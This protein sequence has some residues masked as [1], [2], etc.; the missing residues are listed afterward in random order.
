VNWQ[1]FPYGEDQESVYCYSCGTDVTIDDG[2]CPACKKIFQGIR[3][4][5]PYCDEINDIDINTCKCSYTYHG[6]PNCH[7]EQKPDTRFCGYCGTEINPSEKVIMQF[8]DKCNN[9]YNDSFKYCE[10]DGNK[11]VQKEV[12]LDDAELDKE[13]NE[14]II[15]EKESNDSGDTQNTTVDDIELINRLDSRKETKNIG[16]YGIGNIQK[17]KAENNDL[18][19]NWYQAFTY[20]IL[21]LFII[22]C[23]MTW[24]GGFFT[25]IAIVSTP[26][27]IF[28]LSSMREWA[29]TF[30]NFYILTS[31]LP[32][33]FEYNNVRM[34]YGVEVETEVLFL[35]TILIWVFWSV[36]NYIYFN[37][38]KHLFV[39]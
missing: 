11:L 20:A 35:L 22:F 25:L 37:K 24:W 13:K 6:C 2:R 9:V 33:L 19:M 15:E 17:A 12:Q 1:I 7:K 36:P 16:N 38:R 10:I 27:L 32:I 26:I 4:A 39:N 31:F 23:A 5:C 14:K 28:G 30:F 34:D 8:C 29:P 3:K 18:P 21:P